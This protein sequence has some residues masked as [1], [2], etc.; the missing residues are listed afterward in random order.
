MPRIMLLSRELKR[1]PLDFDFPVDDTWTGYLL[2]SDLHERGCNDCDGTG[3]SPEARRLKDRW[4]GQIPFDPSETGSERLTPDTPLV[5]LFAERNIEH[6]PEFYGSDEIAIK[7]E[8]LRLANLW[9]GQWSHHLE[10]VDVDALIAAQRLMDFTHTWSPEAGWQPRD[11]VPEVTAAEVNEWAL[12]GFGHDS[13]N[14]AIVIEAKCEREGHSDT[15]STCDGQGGVE[16]YPGQRLDAEAWEPT[17]PPEGDGYQLWQTV[18]EGGP[19][20]PVFATATELAEW[21]A[22]N[23]TGIL[24]GKSVAEWLDILDGK[25]GGAD[26]ETG[27]LAYAKESS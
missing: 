25:V 27:D 9:N 15:C 4:Y 24:A 18:S 2:P 26:V 21:L 14:C 7:R 3:Y 12:T 6:A 10:Q 16:Q 5:R 23:D 22:T 20:S 17:E 11:P 13:L 8:A 1:V 19:C